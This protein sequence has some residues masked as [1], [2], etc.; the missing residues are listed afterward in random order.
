[1]FP[2]GEYQICAAQSPH[3]GVGVGGS[4]QRTEN[5]AS[6]FFPVFTSCELPLLPFFLCSYLFFASDVVDLMPSEYDMSP[7]I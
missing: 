3:Q 6:S 5:K 4:S 7:Y 2:V 1:M